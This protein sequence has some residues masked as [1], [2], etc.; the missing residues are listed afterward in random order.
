MIKRMLLM[1]AVAFSLAA[2]GGGETPAG[3]GDNGS[4]GDNGGGTG[5]PPFDLTEQQ[6]ARFLTHAT[7]GV[8]REGVAELQSKGLDRWLAEQLAMPAC[9]HVNPRL[10]RS[11]TPNITKRQRMRD[12]IWLNHAVGC[13][14]Q[15]KERVAMALSEIFVVSDKHTILID[16]QDGIAH[17]YQMLANSSTRNFRDL[18]Y[19]VTL[20]PV[21]GGYL[22]V[23]GNEKP[24]A[25]LN[26][27]P[28]ENYAR[29]VMQLFSIGLVELNPDGSERLDALGN[30]IPTYG[31]ADIEG[32]AH[33]LTGWAW[34]NISTVDE[35]DEAKANDRFHF[36]A[37]YISQMRA[38]ESYHDQGTK[39]FLNF[40]VPSSQTA[41]Q[42]MEMVIDV[43]S[44]HSNVAPF[45]SKQLIQ[46]LVKSN[47]SPAYVERVA[48][49][50]NANEQGIWGDMASVIK[51]ILTDDEALALPEY[52]ENPGKLQQPLL[53]L[54]QLLRGFDAVGVD[55]DGNGYGFDYHAIDEIGQSPLSAPSV[56]N[57]YE[58]TSATKAL[59]DQ[60][61]V[62]PEFKL[63][64][65]NAT[66]RTVNRLSN[67]A[68]S[69]YVGSGVNTGIGAELDYAPHVALLAQ[70]PEA[71]LDEL[72]L[73]LMQGV[74][75]DDM[76]AALLAAIDDFQD[77]GLVPEQVVGEVVSLIISSPQYLIQS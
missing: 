11:V 35:W 76:Q 48:T 31:Q 36:F 39:Y 19:D 66:P 37:D 61:L 70:S 1:A 45:I 7:M 55:T 43:I 69:G 53:R 51:A 44:R 57:F 67:L 3:S 72:G 46:R 13:K 74:M 32:L 28:D 21:M 10:H 24:N 40:T 14:A 30:P 15:L 50:F 23:L 25:D 56:F 54:T 75:P 60:E 63:V 65:E 2:C 73:L 47:P 62:A 9:R 52:Q 20:H 71:L 5:Y 17:Y 16:H 42:D 22:N 29:E 27:R 49:V 41:E 18:L 34:A 8:T 58:P 64:D 59:Q 4:G 38:I 77:Q 6:A 12:Q 68:Q 26:V 33:A